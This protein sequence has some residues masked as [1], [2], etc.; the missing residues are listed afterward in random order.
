[1]TYLKLGVLSLKETH[2]TTFVRWSGRALGGRRSHG[3][4]SM[5][6]GRRLIMSCDGRVYWCSDCCSIDWLALRRL[7]DLRSSLR[8]GRNL[9]VFGRNHWSFIRWSLFGC[10]A[11]DIFSATEEITK[12]RTAFATLLFMVLC[13]LSCR[14]FC[15]GFICLLLVRCNDGGWGYRTVSSAFKYWYRDYLPAAAT[16]A[17]PASAMS[18]G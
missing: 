3:C 5:S 8:D 9:V 1:M 10:W 4:L 12:D 14:E 13:T 17:A 7:I 11:C 2:H 18:D 15:F 16:V 6:T